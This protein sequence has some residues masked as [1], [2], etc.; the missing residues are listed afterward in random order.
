M[1][2][3]DKYSLVF[4]YLF[5]WFLFVCFSE[6]WFLCVVLTVLEISEDQA[7]LELIEIHLPLL[8]ECP[9]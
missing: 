9:D 5:V 6:T 8:P 3:L 4:V 1:L 7:G 2:A